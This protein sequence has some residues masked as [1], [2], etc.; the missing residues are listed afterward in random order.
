MCTMYVL[1]FGSE[2]APA[3]VD[4]MVYFVVRTA[5]HEE[6]TIKFTQLPWVY[7]NNIKYTDRM[8]EHECSVQLF[9]A[10]YEK[11]LLKP[12]CRYMYCTV[13]TTK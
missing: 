8:N 12:S 1:W 13:H 2:M 7:L 3:R 11:L 5:K 10:K 4:V 9:T 6:K